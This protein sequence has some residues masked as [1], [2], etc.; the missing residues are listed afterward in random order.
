[1]G[2]DQVQM[3][4]YTSDCLGDGGGMVVVAG[5]VICYKGQGWPV[6]IFYYLLLF[7]NMEMTDTDSSFP[8]KWRF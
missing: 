6:N 1:M 4:C 2:E 7:L 3:K 8:Y 5:F